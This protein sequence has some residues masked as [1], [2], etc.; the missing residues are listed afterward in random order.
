MTASIWLV[1]GATMGLFALAMVGIG[2]GVLLANKPIRGSCG[3]LAVRD[4]DGELLNCA[5]CPVRQEAEESGAPLQECEDRMAG[6]PA[7]C[8]ADRQRAADFALARA[9]ESD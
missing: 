9:G 3:G 2:V 1:L 5:D 7:D 4:A 6:L 8:P